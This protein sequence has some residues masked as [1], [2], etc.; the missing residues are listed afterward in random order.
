MVNRGLPSKTRVAASRKRSFEGRT[1]GSAVNIVEVFQN[2]CPVA[3]SHPRPRRRRKENV[4]FLKV[5]TGPDVS[6]TSPVR[7][8][9]SAWR[10]PSRPHFIPLALVVI[11]IITQTRDGC[12]SCP[13]IPCV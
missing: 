11:H 8:R 4:R 10:A 7:S 6:S 9:S 5:N 12:M 13:P 1:R 2:P 3:T